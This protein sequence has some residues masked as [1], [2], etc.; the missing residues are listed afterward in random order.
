MRHF[1]SIIGMLICGLAYAAGYFAGHNGWWPAAIVTIVV[2]PI[3][4]S[5]LGSG[6]H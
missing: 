1:I 3:I 6:R 4:Y 2:Y 5:L